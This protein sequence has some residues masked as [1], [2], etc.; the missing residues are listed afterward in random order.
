MRNTRNIHV[1]SAMQTI[2]NLALKKAGLANRGGTDVV[3]YGWGNGNIRPVSISNMPRSTS[4][5][6]VFEDQI[7]SVDDPGGGAVFGVRA[8][9]GAVICAIY[10]LQ[11]QRWSGVHRV[12]GGHGSETPA[13][14]PAL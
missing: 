10:D 11:W 12:V 14:G 2:W 3:E 4:L 1:G 5:A 9:T 6:S 8:A 13:A 7:R